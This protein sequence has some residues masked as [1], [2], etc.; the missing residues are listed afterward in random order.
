MGAKIVKILSKRKE[1][2]PKCVGCGVDVRPGFH[3]T[4]SVIAGTQFATLHT[5]KQ[6]PVL[7]T[8]EAFDRTYILGGE[9]VEASKRVAFVK[10][11]KGPIC[12]ECASNYHTVRDAA[13]NEH[14]IVKTDPLPGF[15]GVTK[16]PVWEK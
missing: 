16:V 12:D 2:Q 13:G 8:M 14:P 3:Y 7:G 1:G 5:Q 4:G 11:L 15:I 9:I 6:L 10:R